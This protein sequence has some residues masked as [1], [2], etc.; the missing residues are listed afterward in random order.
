VESPGGD[1]VG[2]DPGGIAGSLLGVSRE[3]GGQRD[4]GACA[5]RSSGLEAGPGVVRGGLRDELGGEPE[6]VE[7]GLRKI[8]F[9]VADG[10]RERSKTEGIGEAGAVHGD[11]RQPSRQGSDRGGRGAAAALYPLLQSAGSGASVAAPGRGGV[12]TGAGVEAS[13]RP[14]GDG[15]VGDRA[16]GVASLQEIS[17]DQRGWGSGVEPQ[18]GSGCAS[19]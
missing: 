12:D 3:Y 13:Y 5:E 2:G 9:G 11:P 16:F 18:G 14:E 7:P 19:V 10:E 15:S 17:A 4:G 8:P 6:G 1:R